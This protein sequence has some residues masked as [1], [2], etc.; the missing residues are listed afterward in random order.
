ML[1]CVGGTAR[2]KVQGG[3]PGELPDA[4]PQ[5]FMEN[6]FTKYGALND[7]LGLAMGLRL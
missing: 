3:R 5:V 4:V 6:L 2:N 7:S 1:S